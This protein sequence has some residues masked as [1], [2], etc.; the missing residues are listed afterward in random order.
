MAGPAVSVIIA[1]D[2]YCPACAHA[3]LSAPLGPGDLPTLAGR[4]EALGVHIGEADANVLDD[5][6]HPPIDCI[7]CGLRLWS[8]Y[9]PPFTDPGAA[10]TWQAPCPQQRALR[11]LEC[12]RV[13]RDPFTVA[14]CCQTGRAAAVLLDYGQWRRARQQPAA[15]G[16]GRARLARGVAHAIL[17]LA[18]VGDGASVCG[19]DFAGDVAYYLPDVLADL[20]VAAERFGPGRM[21]RVLRQA[22][23]LQAS[24]APAPVPDWFRIAPGYGHRATRAER[25]DAHLWLAHAMNGAEHATV[26]AAVPSALGRTALLMVLAHLDALA[27][28]LGVDLDAALAESAQLLAAER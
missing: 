21:T 27:R 18:M 3:T 4:A 9:L 10:R 1:G 14:A 12:D 2:D 25:A 26:H 24:P 22:R 8:P 11:C 7:G 19:G 16:A 15:G 28:H 17:V 20:R 5:E 23:V 13:D 6:E